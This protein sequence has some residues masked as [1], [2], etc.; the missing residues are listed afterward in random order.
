MKTRDLALN[1]IFMALYVALITFIPSFGPLQF[2][3]GEAL[4]V[5][6]FYNRKFVPAFVLGGILA[7]LSSPLGTVD[8]VV[9]GLCAAITYTI[10]YF[11]K[12][13]YINGVTYAVVSGVLVA[14]ELYIIQQTPLLLSFGGVAGSMIVIQ[15]GAVACVEHTGLKEIITRG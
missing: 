11:V 10:S 15:L 6:P 2:R 1:G 14:A 8:M 3:I 7:N 5:M 13:P 9:G 12:R 4:C